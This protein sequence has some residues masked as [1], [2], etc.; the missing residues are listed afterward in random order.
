[1]PAPGRKGSSSG[2]KKESTPQ[3]DLTKAIKQVRTSTS[4]LNSAPAPQS[5]VLK[6]YANTGNQTVSEQKRAA[7]SNPFE[8]VGATLLAALNKP[9]QG[10]LRGVQNR[11]KGLSGILKGVGQGLS[12][13]AGDDTT[14]LRGAI[15]TPMLVGSD[16]SPAERARAEAFA[17]K[18]GGRVGGLF[19]LVGTAAIDPLSYVGG[20]GV[21]GKVGGAT[22]A[23]LK[24]VEKGAG[25]ELAQQIATQGARKLAPE[26]LDTVRAALASSDAAKNFKGGPEAYVAK[27]LGGDAKLIG[28]ERGALDQALGLRLGGKTVV[29]ADQLGRAAKVTGATKAVNALGDTRA[30]Q[31]LGRAFKPRY[32]VAKALGSEAADTLG[33]AVAGSKGRAAVAK[34]DVGR[35]ITNLAKAAEKSG[36]DIAT[37]QKTILDPALESGSIRQAAAA[38]RA[39]GR[40]SA[41][42]LADMLAEAKVGT[43]EAERTTAATLGRAAATTNVV[44]APSRGF[45]QWQRANPVEARQLFPVDPQSADFMAGKTIDEVNSQIERVTGVKKAFEPS[46][47]KAVLARSVENIDKQARTALLD[48][49][50]KATPNGTPLAIKAG[51]KVPDGFVKVPGTN[52]KYLA[53]RTVAKEIARLD[54]KLKDPTQVQALLEQSAK[55]TQ[56]VKNYTLNAA[57]FFVGRVG[58]DAFGNQISMWA[59]G[60]KNPKAYAVAIRADKALRSAMKSGKS[61]DEAIAALPADLRKFEELMAKRGTVNSGQLRSDITH[62]SSLAL[63]K[64]ERRKQRI[65]PMNAEAFG[66][67]TGSNVN[68]FVDDVSRRA[69]FIDQ[70]WQH[71]DPDIAAR[72]VRETLFDYGDLTDVEK[73]IRQVVWFY[74]FMA[75][76]LELQ[77]TIL[78]NAPAKSVNAQRALEA[79]LAD[80]D[81][82]DGSILPQNQLASGQNPLFK[83]GDTAIMGG[84]QTPLDA[85]AQ[86]VQPLSDIASFA[87]PEKYTTQAGWQGG[88]AGLLSQVGGAPG[89][90]AKQLAE[91]A[92]GSDI[93]TGAPLKGGKKDTLYRVLESQLPRGSQYRKTAEEATTGSDA[94]RLARLLST[95]G[96]SST[97]V[98][99]KR[100]LSEV[101]RRKRAIEESAN[102]Q[103][104]PTVSE[105]KKS[106]KT[107][108]T[109]ST[110]RKQQQTE[111]L[112][113]LLNGK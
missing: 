11:D 36:E 70:M 85:A 16:A 79:L 42:K 63:T 68:T 21:V 59:K 4:R 31:G 77:A 86:A 2:K 67:K 91:E 109:T 106:S 5:N 12:T 50:T 92:S 34:D 87:A 48:D 26:Q 10:V 93:F 94:E 56:L 40:E 108:S 90:A 72:T 82:G 39:E 3:D 38:L 9:S 1:M 97:A 22:G 101:L 74:T 112:R 66:T 32:D 24:A 61:Y 71:G 53:H 20:A 7:K 25:K 54:G 57:P 17:E 103:K 15:I 62:A 105:L 49:L 29:T 13:G 96:L 107:S 23:G 95:A 19:D 28:R 80:E 55:A 78:A 69:M 65:N 100:Q 104:I 98:T 60:F 110:D 14:N 27:M 41:A 83:V 99:D 18:Q 47:S 113:K 44:R 51:Q 8:K 75:R 89:G 33:L 73:S 6:S 102:R 46:A 43:R 30:A 64:G 88:I 84:I 37:L 58:R 35:Q 52:G 45:T 111:A 81:A 76:N